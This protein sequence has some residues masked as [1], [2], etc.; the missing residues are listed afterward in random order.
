MGRRDFQSFP[1]DEREKEHIPNACL[2]RILSGRFQTEIKRD[3]LGCNRFDDSVWPC[4]A[5]HFALHDTSLALRN[6]GT[7]GLPSSSYDVRVLTY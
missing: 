4:T 2:D 6:L 3:Q 5:L 7:H 1:S